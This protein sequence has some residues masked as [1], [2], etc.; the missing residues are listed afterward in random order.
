[1]NISAL[2]VLVVF[3]VVF[4]ASIFSGM[5][6]GGGGLIVVPFLIAI[7]LSPQQAIATTKF[8][9]IGFSGG[10]IAAF[11]KRSFKNPGLLIFLTVLA[12]LISLI[13]P[14]IF[15]SINGNQFQIAIGLMMIALVPTTLSDK[16]GLRTKKTKINQKFYGGIL[17]SFTLLLQG[18]FSSGVGV[19]NN[20]VLMSFFG[21]KVLDANAVQRV[22]AL[23][24]NTFIVIA[25][26]TTTN[27]IVWQ[28][29]I[30]GIIASFLGSYIGSD[31]AIA[32]GERFAK[33]ALALFM[34]VAGIVLIVEA[35]HN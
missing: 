23:A 14:P 31:I 26:A 35:L 7:G 18:I 29:A 24:L 32:R 11:K 34:W 13:V 15:K 28:Y 30:A 21:L 16:F 12:F 9:A 22:A 6:G 25:L 20:L 19:L 2:N 8:G 4:L 27:F 3:V 17:L 5:S 1:M 33:Y 10:G